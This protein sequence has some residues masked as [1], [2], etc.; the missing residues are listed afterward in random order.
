M[1]YITVFRRPRSAPLGARESTCLVNLSRAVLAEAEALFE[2]FATLN[3]I[4]SP[5][6]LAARLRARGRETEEEIARR[7]SR[8]GFALPQGLKRVVEIRNDGPLDATVSAILAALHMER[9]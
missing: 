5:D 7:L 1:G 3:L 4:A 8:S 2:G 6:V 9:V